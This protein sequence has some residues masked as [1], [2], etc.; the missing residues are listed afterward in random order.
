MLALENLIRPRPF[1]TT[2]DNGLGELFE[3]KPDAADY[4]TPN[5]QSLGPGLGDISTPAPTGPN[6]I[7]DNTVRPETGG[8]YGGRQ[9]QRPGRI[10]KNPS[11]PTDTRPQVP[12]VFTQ[13]KPSNSDRN[14]NRP[15]G[16]FD[17]FST[18]DDTPAQ[19]ETS[20]KPT[21]PN[22]TTPS[23]PPGSLP[24]PGGAPGNNDPHS[25]EADV[26]GDSTSEGDNSS[27]EDGGKGKEQD[28]ITCEQ[29]R[30]TGLVAVFP[31]CGWGKQSQGGV[32]ASLAHQKPS[33]IQNIFTRTSKGRSTK[34]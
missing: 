2:G 11:T 33:G 17:P 27:G 22:E 28:E 6:P 4:G 32:V 34:K 16:T 14:R 18:A 15:P 8:E 30:G 3:P 19:D 7:G 1:P 31:V 12:E 24:K 20:G 21:T 23:N 25:T 9:G 10:P 13:P 5:D 29:L 26:G